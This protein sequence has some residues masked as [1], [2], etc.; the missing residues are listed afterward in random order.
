MTLSVPLRPAGYAIS[1]HLSL[2]SRALGPQTLSASDKGT[3]VRLIMEAGGA[4]D[5]V[6]CLLHLAGALSRAG[7]G[8]WEG[9]DDSH[10]LHVL[11]KEPNERGSCRC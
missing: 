5:E 7:C 9:V 11:R 6:T 3:V 8:N 10:V 4:D 2:Q 1:P